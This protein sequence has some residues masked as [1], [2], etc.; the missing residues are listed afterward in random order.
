MG[1]LANQITMNTL[2]PNINTEIYWD[3][4]YTEGAKYNIREINEKHGT[5]MKYVL[6]V[7]EG[8]VLEV[9]CGN[10]KLCL[11]MRE[12]KQPGIKSITG[13]DFSQV[14]IDKNNVILE[15][16]KYKNI[17]F[18]QMNAY[19][20]DFPENSFDTICILETMEHLSYIDKFMDQVWKVARNGAKFIA[21]VP[22]KHAIKSREHVL[23]YTEEK[24]KVMFKQ[25]Y[26]NDVKLFLKATKWNNAAR[27][28]VFG[29][30]IIK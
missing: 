19:N 13:I 7:A 8:D 24:I 11:A 4:R 18:L 25:W 26:R 21:T 27:N 9:G 10:G 6:L 23:T 16:I 29:F 28:I 22:Y 5:Y 30:S 12:R 14:I 2:P 1:L 3:K 20:L 17:K 15:K